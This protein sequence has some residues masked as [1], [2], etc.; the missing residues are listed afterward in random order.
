MQNT[1]RIHVVDGPRGRDPTEQWKGQE[2]N[3]CQA[4]TYSLHAPPVSTEHSIGPPHP[5]EG[6]KV[7]MALHAYNGTRG[8]IRELVSARVLF[9]TLHSQNGASFLT[10]LHHFF[11]TKAT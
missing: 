3:I 2:S 10:I 1:A 4:S 9:P 11:P 8:E 6:T 5:P 7:L